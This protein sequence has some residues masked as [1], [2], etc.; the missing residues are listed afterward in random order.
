MEFFKLYK[1]NPVILYNMAVLIGNIYTLFEDLDNINSW[2]LWRK[3]A[4][5]LSALESLDES[6][7]VPELFPLDFS[8]DFTQQA[9]NILNRL[10][11][12][13]SKEYKS[14]NKNGI[15]TIK[16]VNTKVK[17]QYKQWRCQ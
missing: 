5:Y 13:K 15:K 12:L 3:Y 6:R 17:N 8:D 10:D 2:D 16:K 11:K 9:K 4:N 1:D 14:N 7:V